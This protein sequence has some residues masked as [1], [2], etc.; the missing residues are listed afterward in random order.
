MTDHELMLEQL[1]AIR[2]AALELASIAADLSE[3]VPISGT[4]WRLG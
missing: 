4:E 2:A 1:K 3:V